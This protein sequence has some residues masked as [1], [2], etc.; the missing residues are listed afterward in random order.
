MPSVTEVSRF[1]AKQFRVGRTS[2]DVRYWRYSLT[3]GEVPVLLFSSSHC[4][5]SEVWH[6]ARPYAWLWTARL[7]EWDEEL[8]ASVRAAHRRAVMATQMSVDVSDEVVG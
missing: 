8:E 7:A 1:S 6:E 3:Q 4:G 5:V 2:L